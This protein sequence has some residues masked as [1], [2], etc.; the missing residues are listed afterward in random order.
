MDVL[1]RYAGEILET[2][3]EAQA[4]EGLPAAGAS[5]YLIAVLR[6]GSIRM[7][8]DAG[9]WSLPALAAE[10]CASAVYRAMRRPRLIRVEAWSAGNTWMLTRDLAAL[11]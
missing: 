4:A 1:L 8:V 10:H 5:E 11:A 2:A 6:G 7:I 9:S 3:A